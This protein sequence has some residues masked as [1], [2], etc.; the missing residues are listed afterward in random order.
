M[1]AVDFR[2]HRPDELDIQPHGYNHRGDIAPPTVHAELDIVLRSPALADFRRDPLGKLLHA[3]IDGVWL[4]HSR[5]SPR[6]IE[7]LR[8]LSV[9]SGDQAAQLAE[10]MCQ[11]PLTDARLIMLWYVA[12]I[13][14][15][16][17]GL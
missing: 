14:R 13:H 17:L 6:C 2:W 11:D 1:P 8:R 7:A 15:S 5:C 9:F 3:V 4:R 16:P 12:C 10:A